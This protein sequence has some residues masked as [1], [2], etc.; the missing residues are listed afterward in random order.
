MSTS[1]AQSLQQAYVAVVNKVLPSVVQIRTASGLGSGVVFDAQGN[2]VT[3][4]HVVGSSKQFEVTLPSS[5]KA[6]AGHAG[7]HVHAW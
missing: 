4:A 7:R 5:S 1:A 6:A 2:I 3:N